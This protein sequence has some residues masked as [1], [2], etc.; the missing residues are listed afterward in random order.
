G[1]REHEKAPDRAPTLEVRGERSA[2]Y[3]ERRERGDGHG[4]PSRERRD[5]GAVL[6]EERRGGKQRGKQR[7]AKA[8][9]VRRDLHRCDQLVGKAAY[10]ELVEN[11][12]VAIGPHKPV[13]R[14]QRRK[15]RRNPDHAAAGLGEQRRV[16]T[17]CER[18]SRRD[19]EEEDNR[20][21]QRPATPCAAQVA[22]EKRKE[23]GHASAPMSSSAMSGIPSSK[24]D[25]SSTAPPF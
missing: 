1:E 15:K 25:A 9:R 10:G 22:P 21:P 2:K 7:Q 3:G 6:G 23:S 5:A 14:Q 13:D 16:R 18:K 12:G 24:C 17:D 8:D 20:Q 19:E 4:E 11:P